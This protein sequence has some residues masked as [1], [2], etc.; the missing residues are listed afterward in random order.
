MRILP[1]QCEPTP[2]LVSDLAAE[3]RG[4]GIVLRWRAD[5]N[6]FA[7]FDVWRAAG[8]DAEAD[9]F[10]RLGA[11]HGAGS[12]WEYVDTTALPGATYAY[13]IEG[14]GFDGTAVGYGPIV[15][16]A[17]PRRDYAL[18][19]VHPFPARETATIA[20]S[21]PQPGPI[22]LEVYDA[23]GR[24]VRGLVDDIRAPD[25]H[26]ATWDGQDDRG[27]PVG[28]GLYFV[29]LSWTGGMRV[30]RAAFVR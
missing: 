25:D 27:L 2:V 1:A 4:D 26:V 9:A 14:R 15:A 24:K 22:R 23:R 21:L 8:T 19:P 17:L 3:A 7:A 6:D 13:R 5:G 30:Q 20:F 28:S 29:R 10:V 11:A 16:R 18:G 12:A